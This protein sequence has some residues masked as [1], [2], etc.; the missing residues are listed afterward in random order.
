[1][2]FDFTTE[3]AE[4]LERPNRFVV[5]VRLRGSGEV[6]RAHCP[7]PGRLRELLLPGAAVHLSPHAAPGRRTA[8]SLRFVEHPQ[9]GVLISLESS[10]ANRLFHEALLARVLPPFAGYSAIE[11]EVTPPG[12]HAGGVRSRFDFRLS[13]GDGSACWV[14]VKSAT[15][16]EEGTALF[17]DAVTSRGRRHVQELAAMAGAGAAAAVCFVI[18]RPDAL[19]LRPQWDRDPD[20]SRALLAAAGAGVG[21]HAFR[22][23]VALHGAEIL[24]PVP[25]ELEDWR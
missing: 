19:R 6:V 13:R 9:T 7:D 12:P 15:L 18:Q 25:V 14:E 22:A 3:P 2:V 11:R 5:V 16:V 1:M 24:G 10:L 21:V 4:F 20:F 23:A 8:H 17:P